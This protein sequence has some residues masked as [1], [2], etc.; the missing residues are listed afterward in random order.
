M[1]GSVT[2]T[3]NGTYSY[4]DEEGLEPCHFTARLVQTGRRFFGSITEEVDDDLA[5]V[6]LQAAFVDGAV[7]DTAVSF[8]KTYDG[9]GGW[10]HSVTYDG[11]LSSEGD[12]IHGEWRIIEDGQ[13]FAGTFIMLRRTKAAEETRTMTA[14]ARIG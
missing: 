6:P 4:P 9:G 2:G 7:H 14:S 3:W 13:V 12:E 5:M 8:V 10:A 1:S 11:R